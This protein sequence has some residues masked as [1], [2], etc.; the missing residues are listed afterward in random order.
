VR[1]LVDAQLPIRHARLLVDAGHDA[2]HTSALANGNRT[3][4]GVFAGLADFDDRVVVTKD[5]DFQNS[6][7]LRSTPRRVLPVTTGNITNN[8]LIALSED[9]Q[10]LIVAA[11]ESS[12]YAEVSSDALIVH[13]DIE[14][15]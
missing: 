5:G 15:T 9:N 13:G 3:P 10:T 2:V 7:T 11:L 8:K 6:H 1:F 14:R 4:D 12:A